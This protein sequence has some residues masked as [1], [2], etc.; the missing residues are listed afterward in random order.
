MRDVRVV[1][2]GPQG[3]GRVLALFLPAITFTGAAPGPSDDDK[4]PAGGEAGESR[5]ADR[6]RRSRVLLID[7]LEDQRELYREYLE[8]AGYDVDVARDGFEGID[9]ALKSPPD[10]VVMDLSMPGLDGFEATQRLKL[11]K[12]TRRIPIIA[13]TAHGSLPREWA[14]SAGCAAYLKKPCYPDDLATEIE[15]ALEE[16]AL[17]RPDPVIPAPAV[18][19]PRVLLAE[20]SVADREL[21]AEYLEFRS[22]IVSVVLDRDQILSEIRRVAANVVVLDL[23]TPRLKGWDV[24]EALA[25]D[26]RMR[27]VPVIGLSRKPLGAA[28]ARSLGASLLLKPCEPEALYIE[29]HRA[30]TRPRRDPD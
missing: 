6:R 25:R 1:P 15:A 24:L 2:A 12:R 27:E 20:G 23:D 9:R 11:L 4:D 17:P 16:A 19:R 28:R 18:V 13:L 22:C 8:F 10:V 30:V 26:E 5:H 14:L 21:F 3:T 7:D 29:V